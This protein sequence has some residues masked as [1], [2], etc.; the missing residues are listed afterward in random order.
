MLDKSNIDFSKYDFLLE[1]YKEINKEGIFIFKNYI[2]DYIEKYWNL[3]SEVFTFHILDNLEISLIPSPIKMEEVNK[4]S[5]FV[6][7]TLSS[8]IFFSIYEDEK[9]KDTNRNLYYLKTLLHELGH[10]F[11]NNHKEFQDILKTEYNN[12]YKNI[13]SWNYRNI[14]EELIVSSL[15][16]SLKD[17]GILYKDLG[18]VENEIE[19]EKSLFENKYRRMTYEFLED[20]KNNKSKDKLKI[21][22][23][24]F[25]SKLVEEKIFE[26]K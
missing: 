2:K 25:I 14:I 16:F 1:N 26:V 18:F 12:K 15:N 21:E 22:L 23:P 6:I 11:I 4:L 3:L 13:N 7:K 17:F 5:A 19:K 10:V 8:K 20:L 24:K 9:F